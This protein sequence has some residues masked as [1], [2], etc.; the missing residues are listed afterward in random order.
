MLHTIE[1]SITTNVKKIKCAGKFV[2][3]KTQNFG[4]YLGIFLK[5]K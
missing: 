4:I 3:K 2:K 5:H 1:F